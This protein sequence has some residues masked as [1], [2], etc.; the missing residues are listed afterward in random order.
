MRNTLDIGDLAQKWYR[1]N[2]EAHGVSH[3]DNDLFRMLYKAYCRRS[4]E[5]DHWERF[6]TEYDFRDACGRI[7]GWYKNT[8]EIGFRMPAGQRG[9]KRVAAAGKDQYTFDRCYSDDRSFE[10]YLI[11]GHHHSGTQ[12]LYSFVLHT[13]VAF[14]VQPRELDGVLQHLGFHPL[15]VKNIH[16]LAIYYVLLTS[17]AP[18]GELR[19]NPFDR[20]RELYFR[21]QKILEEPGDVPTDAYSYA[22]KLTW[23]IRNDLFVTQTLS[24]QNFEKLV[25]LNKDSLNMRH[26]MIL[27]DFHMLTSVFFNV[28]DDTDFIPEDLPEADATEKSYSFY[29]FVGRYCRKIQS[30]KTKGRKKQSPEE[31]SDK[32]LSRDKYREWLSSMIAVSGKH[33]TRDVMILLWMFAYCFVSIPG[34]YMD[35]TPFERIKRQIEKADP[36]RKDTTDS[37]YDGENLDVYGLITRSTKPRDMN[38]FRGDEMIEYI[39]EKLRLYDWGQLNQKLS[40]DYYI[41]QLE[42]L[43]LRM[44]HSTGFVRCKS[45]MYQDAMLTGVPAEVDN[46]PCPLVAITWIMHHIK[47]VHLLHPEVSPVP[48]ECGLYEQL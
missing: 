9:Q 39:N 2:H 23:M 30:R 41:Q 3:R 34:V 12:A 36:S 19:E 31:P 26:S 4:G 24:S 11:K 35:T 27:K 21:A 37:F 44:D 28:F 22:D 10:L 45:I 6:S 18:G 7:Y 46:V 43:S 42:G 40:F 29:A 15:H 8:Y 38:E 17:D 25:Q 32:K 33:P 1:E 20:V 13:A 16:H 47:A 48:L 5:E 14:L